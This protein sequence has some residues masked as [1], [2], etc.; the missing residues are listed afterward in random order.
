MIFVSSAV[1]T[2][3]NIQ[4]WL[5][6]IVGLVLALG[7]LG[8]LATFVKSRPEGSKIL[9]DAATGVVV[10]QTGVIT[11]LRSQLDETRHELDKAKIQIDEL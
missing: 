1:D 3:P 5:P 6:A 11:E 4:G 10:V 2:V 8:G 7:G 9:I